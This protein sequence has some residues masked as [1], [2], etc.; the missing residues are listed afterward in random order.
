[1]KKV[2]EEK[3]EEQKKQLRTMRELWDSENYHREAEL[4]EN[5]ERLWIFMPERDPEWRVTFRE[6]DDWLRKARRLARW[7]ANENGENVSDYPD[8]HCFICEHD[9]C[10]YLGHRAAAAEQ[11]KAEM[12]AE[13]E[14]G[15]EWKNNQKRHW[16]YRYYTKIL[17]G[18]L[19]KGARYK[20]PDCVV[21]PTRNE[22]PDEAGSY[23][24]YISY[25][26]SGDS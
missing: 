5:K 17:R 21:F 6:D 25:E 19:G 4:E 20:L 23:T 9:P 22:Y 15:E 10:I 18:F 3:T 7:T 2:D 13:T 16:L 11:M 26:E 24:G 1:M 14:D 8:S 12:D